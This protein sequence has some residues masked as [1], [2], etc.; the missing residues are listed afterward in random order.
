MT[1]D[2]RNPDDET[3]EGQ[4]AQGTAPEDRG[5]A[6][7]GPPEDIENDPAYNPE[8]ENLKGIKGG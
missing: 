5:G 2:E 1:D 7:A 3:D 6:E 8:D 4:D